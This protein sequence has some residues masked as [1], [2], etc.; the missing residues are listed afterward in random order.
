MAVS[1]DPSLLSSCCVLLLEAIEVVG[2]TMAKIANR[3]RPGMVFSKLFVIAVY[4]HGFLCADFAVLF[5]RAIQ[6]IR[7]IGLL[8]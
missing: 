3:I 6:S 1:L 5:S 4:T 2:I 7:L 8:S